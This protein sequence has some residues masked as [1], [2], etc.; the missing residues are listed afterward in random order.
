MHPSTLLYFRHLKEHLIYS[1]KM[2]VDKCQLSLQEM[3]EKNILM[4]F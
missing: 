4:Y 3:K 1:E 2:A